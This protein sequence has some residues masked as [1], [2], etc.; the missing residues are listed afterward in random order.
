MAIIVAG[1]NSGFGTVTPV[2]EITIGDDGDAA[3]EYMQIDAEAGVPPAGECDANRESGRMIL[4][5]TNDRLYIC[6]QRSGRGWDYIGL[7]N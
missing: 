2:S 5:Y 1:G 4:D 3:D 6:N 7:T